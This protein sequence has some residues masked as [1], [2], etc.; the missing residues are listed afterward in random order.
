M[1]LVAAIAGVIAVAWALAYV[2]APLWVWTVGAAAAYAA[3]VAA[4]S[5]G[6]IGAIALGV[7]LA[8]LAFLN[9][10]PLRRSLIT[11]PVFGVFKKVLPEMSSTEREA[12]EAGDV[13]LEAEMF[14]GRPDWSKLLS[15][16]YT[17]LTRE[18]QSFLDN[19]VEEL[20]KLVDDWKL[21]FEDRDLP[22][23]AWQ[24]LRSHRFFAMLIKKEYGGLGFSAAA[25]SAVVTKLATKSITL[26]VTV[27]VPNSL[28]PGELLM[29]Y[30]TDA[31]KQQWLP[32]LVNGTELPCFGLTG[33]EVGSDATAMPDSGVVCYGEH[34]GSRVLGIKLN[35]S[36]RYIT[37]APVATVVGLAFNLRDPQGLL[38][39]ATRSATPTDLG[40][41][42]ALVPARHAGIHIGRRHYPGAAF[43]NGPIFGKDVFIPVEWII[44]GPK[45][46]GKG[47]RM[48]VECLSA[49][50]GISLPALATAGGQAAY[51]MVGAYG[52]IRRQFRMAVGKFEGVQEATGRIAGNT[53]T[54]E[55]MRILTA[56]AVDHC[57]PSVVTAIAKY[58]MTELLRKVVTDAMDVLSGRGIQQG[59]RNPLSTAYKT[60]PIA[61]TVEGANILTRN[62]MIFGQGA[63][64]CHEYV[65]PEMEAARDNDL[66]AF[67]KLLFGH[68]G[69]SINRG[70][71]ALTLGLSGSALAKSP[72]PGAMAPYFKQFERFSA[73]LAFSSDVTMGVLGGELKRK[74]RLSARLGDVL[75]QLYIGCA[76]MKFY[77]DNGQ[78]PE[79]LDHARW[80]L[81]QCLFEI[82]K[83]FD[84]FF[85]NFPVR[86]V[87]RVMRLAAFPLGN[88]YKP[89]SDAL[90][91][92][93]ADQIMEDSELRDRLSHLVF[94]NGG[95]DEATGRIEHAFKLLQKAEAPYLK[96]FKAVAKGELA[97]HDTDSRLAE[98]VAR[99]LLNPEES[100]LVAEYDAARYDVILT[101]DFSAEY[102]AGH[103]A[104]EP[105]SRRAEIL[106][107]TGNRAR[108]A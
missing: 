63:I 66:V 13:W 42:C 18:E 47:W 106:E 90:N 3:G 105:E 88:H 60:V 38:G 19:E 43:M 62:L 34:E 31:Q 108:V 35:F 81:D 80:A 4:G 77:I 25:Q 20:C 7:P 72:M 37:L 40:I 55:A 83:A 28:G 96:Y 57:A 12:L 104:A 36:K 44:G 23:A 61:I 6:L 50:R 22:A 75:S 24:Y 93:L 33:P 17:R 98:A 86:I 91:A 26:A 87:A 71:R 92:R 89:V 27:M 16:R 29:H 48:L 39:D 103:Y 69:F 59:P 54:L 49:G 79:E 95:K 107:F 30:G 11:R 9:I 85:D 74:E 15:F 21:E 102:V 76:V 51:R 101:D 32:G 52:R 78:K 46:A 84:G 99:G 41:T 97:G 82:G 70:V 5:I 56:S 64:R 8:L 58:H 14:R 53:Y 94:V 2:G 73:A 67:D 65:F 1:S 10:V 68:I 45:N 100:R